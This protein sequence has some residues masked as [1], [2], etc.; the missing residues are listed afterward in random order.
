MTTGA[1]EANKRSVGTV[2]TPAQDPRP[3]TRL[4]LVGAPPS[5]P[6]RS[7]RWNVGQGVSY[8]VVGAPP[9]LVRMTTLRDGIP[10]GGGAIGNT[11]GE[12]WRESPLFR[13]LSEDFYDLVA[14]MDQ[15]EE[16]DERLRPQ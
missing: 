4:R 13:E 7:A 15:E 16:E 14:S 9:P 12:W 6:P 5:F 1:W 11:R 8:A 2:A 10:V 3:A